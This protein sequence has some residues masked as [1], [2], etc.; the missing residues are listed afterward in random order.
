MTSIYQSLDHGIIAALKINYRNKLLER[1]VRN[2]DKLS[3][4]AGCAGLDYGCPAHIA[5]AMTILKQVWDDAGIIHT[6]FQ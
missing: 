3:Q 5:D 4:P 2:A 6:V 1:L